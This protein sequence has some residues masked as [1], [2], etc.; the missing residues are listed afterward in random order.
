MAKNAWL[1]T[2]M[3]LIAGGIFTYSGYNKLIK[4]VQEFQ[5]VIEQYQTFPSF[6]VFWIAHILP[7][8]EFIFG[9]FL[10]I[11]FLRFLSAGI[12]SL[13]S[14]AFLILL[15]SSLI[16]GID[17]SHCGCFGEGIHLTAAQAVVLDSFLVMMLVFLSRYPFRFMELDQYL[18]Y[19]D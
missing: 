8:A 18:L 19:Q 11:G 4:P 3:R 5:Y 9:V 15:S 1:V 17:I 16:R 10:V 6:L 12:L 13:M 2:L 14:L 7:W